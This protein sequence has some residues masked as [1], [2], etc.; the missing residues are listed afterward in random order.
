MVEPAQVGA[1]TGAIDYHT[2]VAR[3][4]GRPNRTDGNG[5]PKAGKSD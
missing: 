2:V 5:P 3:Y 1:Q 4:P